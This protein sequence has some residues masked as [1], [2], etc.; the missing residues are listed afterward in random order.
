[1]QLLL[2]GLKIIEM[3]LLTVIVYF[4]SLYLTGIVGEIGE[5]ND[6]LYIWTHKKFDMGHNEDKVSRCL[7]S[8]FLKKCSLLLLLIQGSHA[9]W[10]TVENLKNEERNF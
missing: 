10:K 7:V 4:V 6:E 2:P 8:L 9:P 5:G 3:L 1:M